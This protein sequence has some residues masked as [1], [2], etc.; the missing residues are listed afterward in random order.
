M[1]LFLLAIALAMDSVALSIASAAQNPKFSPYAAVKI[2]FVFGFFQALMPFFGYILGIRFVAFISEIDHFIAFAILVFLG[3]KMIKESRDERKENLEI[4]SFKEL[5]LG[6]IATSI[7]ALSVGITFSFSHTDILY[8]CCLIG[9]V[10]FVLCVFACYI[11]RILG[12]WLGSKA[13]ILGGVML[14]LIACSILIEHL[15]LI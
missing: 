12:A 8:A 15:K 1:L 2:S 13:L 5:I 9:I 11:G 6:A 4:L 3:L 14:I 10:C 7:D